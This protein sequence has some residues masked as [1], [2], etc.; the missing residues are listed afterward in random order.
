MKNVWGLRWYVLCVAVVRVSTYPVNES[1]HTTRSNLE[2]FPTD[3]IIEDLSPTK[4][5][6]VDSGLEDFDFNPEDKKH[7]K[8]ENVLSLLTLEPDAEMLPPNFKGVVPPGVDHMELRFR[9]PQ[10]MASNSRSVSD[11]GVRY[12]LFNQASQGL[13]NENGH[14]KLVEFENRLKGV[15]GK[16]KQKKDYTEAGGRKKAHTEIKNDFKN[17][18]DQVFDEKNRSYGI[19]DSRN[20]DYKAAGFHS[21]YHKDE[22]NK[23]SDFYDNDHQG[24]HFKKHGRYGEKHSSLEHIYKKGSSHDSAFDLAE[25]K[26]KEG[27]RSLVKEEAQGHPAV[28]LTTG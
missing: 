13:K 18:K 6:S 4:F 15:K 2:A 1:G 17:R 12:V 19:K 21:V 26:K 3:Y 11:N 9:E 24:G 7:T 10:V 14:K 16:E 27:L 8:V 23:N 25:A 28:L 5:I 22:H 20:K